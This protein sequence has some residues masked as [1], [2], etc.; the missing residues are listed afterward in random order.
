MTTLENRCEVW[1]HFEGVHGQFVQVFG[2]FVEPFGWVEKAMGCF[3]VM[4]EVVE[5]VEEAS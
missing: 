2:Q 5:C 1:E 4:R 3:D